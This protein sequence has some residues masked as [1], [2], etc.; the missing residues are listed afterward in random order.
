MNRNCIIGAVGKNSLHKN[1][2]RK[3]ASYDLHLI[4]YDDSIE[5]YKNDT[6]YICHLSGMKLKIVSKYLQMNPWVLYKYN[7]FL[8]PDDDILIKASEIEKLFYN[9]RHFKLKI[10]QPAL[11]S[12]YYSWAVT[13]H[14]RYSIL[15][16]TNFVEMM[17]P[18]FSQE[19]LRNVLFTFID[20]N[21]GWGAD[22]HWHSLIGGGVKDMAILDNV[23]AMHTRPV[24]KS[25]HNNEM[26]LQKY[27][28]KYSLNKKILVFSEI[29]SESVRLIDRQTFIKYKNILVHWAQEESIKSTYLGLKGYCGYI[30]LHFLLCEITESRHFA[31]KGNDI[32]LSVAKYFPT[33]R[34][35]MDFQTGLPGVC[36]LLRILTDNKL[37]EGDIANFLDDAYMYIE[38]KLI[39]QWNTM[40]V[41]EK[42]GIAKY[43]LTS[44]ELFTNNNYC[45]DNDTFITN[46]LRESEIEMDSL[47]IQ[48][49]TV[50]LEISYKR[51]KDV[52]IL[53]EI[54][55]RKI[56]SSK[57]SVLQKTFWRYKLYEVT[58]DEH[59]G[60]L[61]SNSLH[62]IP[63]MM[64]NLEDAIMI[65][66]II[67]NK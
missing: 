21:S 24:Q 6:K 16:Y 28:Q 31:D 1:W 25:R 57:V 46:L 17:V 29:K 7:Y 67:S 60:A 56:F 23:S 61:I 2:I 51:N 15:R 58:K 40:S 27:L 49:L 11:V 54:I 4:V 9:M 5:K 38:N 18:C 63:S 35:N 39:S 34:D 47:D 55:E 32:F 30:Y 8:I 59:I 42:L 53:Q 26:E 33:L 22:F 20:N 43:I 52:S 66:E 10:A 36:W 13:L 62:N 14:D 48:Y 12:S 64:L 3:N 50:L 45:S 41:C 44:D 65:A 37:F 19:A